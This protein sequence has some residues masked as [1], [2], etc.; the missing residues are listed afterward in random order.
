MAPRVTTVS[1]GAPHRQ[2]GKRPRGQNQAIVRVIPRNV[3]WHLL[4]Q[5]LGPEAHTPQILTIFL[6]AQGLGPD[7][8]IGQINAQN[9][10][11]ITAGYAGFH[12]FF[13]PP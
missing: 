3:R 10:A 8:F 7:P 9:L 13:L 4:V 5:D 2:A 11:G 12:G 1:P 6:G